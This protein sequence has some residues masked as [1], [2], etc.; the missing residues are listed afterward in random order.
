M[1]RCGRRDTEVKADTD[2]EDEEGDDEEMPE[3]TRVHDTSKR[4]ERHL[5]IRTTNPDEDVIQL[6]TD[7]KNP[8]GENP[9]LKIRRSCRITNRPNISG[10]KPSAANFSTKRMN[11]IILF[12]VEAHCRIDRSDRQCPKI[13]RRRRVFTWRDDATRTSV[14]K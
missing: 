13:F 2:I 3:E 1:V 11:F 5:P 12:R 9:E 14:F 4:D 8:Q 7:G 6:L 10:S